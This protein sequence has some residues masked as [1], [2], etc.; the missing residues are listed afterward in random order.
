[1]NRITITTGTSEDR[2]GHAIPAA[3]LDTKLDRIRTYL[4]QEYGGFTEVQTVGGW[5]NDE[6]RLVIELGR[7][8]TI[9]TADPF[10]TGRQA[11]DFI[12][13]TLGQ[14]SV[15]LERDRD[16]DVSFVDAGQDAAA[17]A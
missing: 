9:A 4:A 3:E 16:A 2:H 13:R 1:M 8:Y 11:A 6:G 17:V 10:T 12:R 7:R 15:M 14:A 5:S